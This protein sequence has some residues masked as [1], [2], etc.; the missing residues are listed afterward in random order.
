MR[1]ISKSMAKASMD[2]VTY[3]Y[4]I[5]DTAKGATLSSAAR[6]KEFSNVNSLVRKEGGQCRL[7]STRGS[8][9]DFVSIISNISPAAAIRIAEGIES[10]GSVKATL[11]SGLEIF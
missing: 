7:Y 2:E 8:S 4:L 1:K 3:I 9:C 10:R 5:E 6:R 11:I